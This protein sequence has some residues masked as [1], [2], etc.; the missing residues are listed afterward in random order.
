MLTITLI[1]NLNITNL[2]ENEFRLLFG[3]NFAVD[4]TF[5]F[6]ALRYFYFWSRISKKV[7]RNYFGRN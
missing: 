4:A 1:N 7:L 6:I 5:L 3:Q 2:V